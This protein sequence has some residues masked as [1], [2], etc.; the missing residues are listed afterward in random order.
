MAQGKKGTG[1]SGTYQGKPCIH[2]HGTARY[3]AGGACVTCSR[4]RSRDQWRSAD[5]AFREK[6]RISARK[7]YPTTL[8]NRNLL[9]D[10]GITLVQYNEMAA[11]QGMNC[12]MCDCQPG[13]PLR[14]DHCHDTGTVRNLLCITCNLALGALKDSPLLAEKAAAY[15]RK[16]GRI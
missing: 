6:K 5:P 14:V 2:G 4:H 13:Y 3:R 12:A 1:L 7:I 16:H 9:R 11:N 15:L 10:Y 8:R